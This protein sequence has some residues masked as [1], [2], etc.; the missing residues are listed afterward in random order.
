MTATLPP[1][2]DYESLCETAAASQHAFSYGL[3]GGAGQ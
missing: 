3:A 2:V 1:A